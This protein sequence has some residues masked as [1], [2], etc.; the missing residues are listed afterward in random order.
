MEP[1]DE[2]LQVIAMFLLFILTLTG[3]SFFI[4]YLINKIRNKK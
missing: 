2:G 4:F 1:Q 3:L